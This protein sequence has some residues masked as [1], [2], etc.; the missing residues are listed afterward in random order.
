[1][2]RWMI[3]LAFVLGAVLSWG[4]YV[5]IVHTASQKLGSNLRA[6]LFVGVAYFLVAV[7]VPS[8]I[9]FGI[10]NDPT[11][12]EGANFRAVPVLWG[13]GRHSGGN[14]S[15][16]RD[17]RRDNCRARSRTLR[18]TAGV[19]RGAD[20]QHDRNHEVFSSD[21]NPARLEVLDGPCHG[22]GRRGNGDAVQASGQALTGSGGRRCI[23]PCGRS[24]VNG[25]WESE[26]PWE[27]AC[28]RYAINRLNGP[29]RPAIK[30][31][32]FFNRR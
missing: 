28:R 5:P 6:F 24:D 7:V 27:A 10:R 1:M 14:W 11:A 30:W 13:L 32:C 17:L 16:V 4:V 25:N 18:R 12:K 23:D 3:V 22:G 29:G 20:R 2:T 21:K 15:V 26:A 9:I 31:Q 8:F 19:R